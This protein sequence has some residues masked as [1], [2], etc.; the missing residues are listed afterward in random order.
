MTRREDMR[1][2]DESSRAPTKAYDFRST[3]I[4]ITVHERVGSG[5][6]GNGVAGRIARKLDVPADGNIFA[7]RTFEIVVP[8]FVGFGL[9]ESVAL[10]RRFL[11]IAPRR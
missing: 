5:D 3:R 10:V 1:G 8:G 6:D 9:F 11:W 7:S 4:D 2:A